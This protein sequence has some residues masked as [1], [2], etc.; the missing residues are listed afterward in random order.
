MASV[1]VVQIVRCCFAL[2][3]SDFLLCIL[4][5]FQQR[6]DSRD[7]LPF[8]YFCSVTN[9]A[10]VEGV[11]CSLLDTFGFLDRLESVNRNSTLSFHMLLHIPCT[12]VLKI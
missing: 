12:Y 5:V 7:S 4:I 9:M 8:C 3:G 6:T 2:A 1:S 11:W 10:F